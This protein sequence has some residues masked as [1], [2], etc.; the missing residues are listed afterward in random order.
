MLLL[1]A[2]TAFVLAVAIAIA[3][4][5]PWL[6]APVASVI[7]ALLPASRSRGRLLHTAAALATVAFA[8]WYLPARLG[9]APSGEVAALAGQQSRLLVRADDDGDRHPTYTAV[10]ATVL[11]RLDGET[12]LPLRGRLR[13]LLPAESE[14]RGG[15]RWLVAG[16]V[17]GA[18]DGGYGDWLRQNGIDGSLSARL[19]QLARRAQAPPWTRAW[20]WLH[21]RIADGLTASL[22]P[23]EAAFAQTLV[24][25]GRHALPADLQDDLNATGSSHLATVSAFNLLLLYGLAVAGLAPWLGRRRAIGIAA[26]LAL[27]FAGAVGFRPAV[28]RGTLLLAWLALAGLSGRPWSRGVALVDALALLLLPQ[29]A[30]LRDAAFQLT[31]AAAFG[32][33]VVGPLLLRALG[34]GSRG[35]GAAIISIAASSASLPVIAAQFGTVSPWSAPANALLTPLVPAMTVLAFVCGLARSATPLFAP[36]AAPLWLLLVLSERT[37]HVFASLPFARAASPAVGLACTVIAAIAVLGCVRCLASVRRGRR[38]SPSRRER[39]KP[40]PLARPV[41]VPLYG[42]AAGAVIVAGLALGGHGGGPGA[43][44]AVTVLPVEG[45]TSLLVVSAS[46]T[47]LL[48]SDSDAPA[49]LAY[50]LEEALPPGATLSAAIPLDGRAGTLAALRAVAGDAVLCPGASGDGR[51]GSGDGAAAAGETEIAL[52]GTDRLLLRNDGSHSLAAVLHAGGR[53]AVLAGQPAAEDAPAGADAV[54]L[55]EWSRVTSHLWLQRLAPRAIVLLGAWPE[56]ARRTLA[57]LLPSASI[58]TAP[59]GTRL[60][61]DGPAGFDR[62]LAR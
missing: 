50:A 2:A 44:T 24:V 53:T 52:G 60:R 23:R 48:L 20:R 3:G 26:V 22:P 8:G 21:A 39:W 5:P 7:A 56:E 34:D 33:A 32:I 13:L 41:L 58:L 51:C 59:P 10:T 40:R 25:G 31:F 49:A 11:A 16:R 45:A 37:V 55:P 9:T 38:P 46:G 62:G 57:A 30:L 18:P 28:L 61:L 36:V 17:D 14:V 1:S 19:A 42:V 54:L 29:P 6:A 43:A 4:L 35:A 15:D 27:C 47:R 12:Q